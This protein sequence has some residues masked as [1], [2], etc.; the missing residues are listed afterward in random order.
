MNPIIDEFIQSKKIAVVGI[1]RSGKKFGNAAS[2][3]LIKRGYEIYPIHPQAKEIDGLTC[4][5]DL[6]SLADQ[7]D[8]LFIS[9]SS[10]QVAPILKDATQIALS[11][12]K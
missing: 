6:K 1:C 4:Y 11:F 2:N 3:E 7:V 9:I 10:S 8:G 12:F 5:P